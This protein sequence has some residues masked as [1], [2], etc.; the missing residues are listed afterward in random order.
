[1]LHGA[2]VSAGLAGLV[3]VAFLGKGLGLGSMDIVAAGSVSTL[4]GNAG[5]FD[6]HFC[7][8]NKVKQG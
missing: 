6:A 1:M 4:L 8:H 2:L 3:L 5:V 7:T